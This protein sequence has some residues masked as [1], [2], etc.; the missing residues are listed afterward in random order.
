L[1]GNLPDTLRTRLASIDKLVDWL[2]SKQAACN[3]TL[4]IVIP[5]DILVYL[6]QH[7]APNH[8]GS[9]TADEKFIAAPGSLFSTKLH[10]FAR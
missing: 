5:E 3:R 1:R 4:L 9:M 2:P 7:W 8:A 6:T 10:T